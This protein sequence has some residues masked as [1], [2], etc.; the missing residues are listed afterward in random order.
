[1]TNACKDCRHFYNDFGVPYTLR[2]GRCR[3]ARTESPAMRHPVDGAMV[4][5]L[6]EYSYASAARANFGMCGVEGKLFERETDLV[7]L[8]RNRYQ[9]PALTVATRVGA[10][11]CMCACMLALFCAQPPPAR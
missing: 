8:A 7:Q 2:F 4:K 1:M 9:G 11:A 3:L 5:P 10:T 6:V